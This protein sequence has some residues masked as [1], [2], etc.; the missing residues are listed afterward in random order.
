MG[1][2]SFVEGTA[3]FMELIYGQELNGS[4]VLTGVSSMQQEYKNRYKN[5]RIMSYFKISLRKANN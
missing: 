3:V 2:M 5:A 1:P 4:G